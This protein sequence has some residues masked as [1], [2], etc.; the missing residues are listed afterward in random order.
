MQTGE[1]R[2]DE[3]LSL[4]EQIPSEANTIVEKF[5]SLKPVSSSALQ[6]QGF[7]QLKNE[8]CMKNRCLQCAIGSAILTGNY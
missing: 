6:S 5:E 2:N 8:Y 3:I 4:V 7:I 1:N